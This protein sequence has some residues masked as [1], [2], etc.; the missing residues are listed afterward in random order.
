VLKAADDLVQILVATA[1]GAPLRDAIKAYGSDWLSAQKAEAWSV[2]ADEHVVGTRF[3]TACYINESM[4]AAL[5]LSW[6]YH[7]NFAAGVIANAMVGGDNCHR[8][9]VVGSLLA[10]AA[11]GIPEKY[12]DGLRPNLNV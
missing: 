10:T 5:Y 4:P 3:S 9:T 12:L 2:E 11:R 6:K 7:D 8:G 1:A